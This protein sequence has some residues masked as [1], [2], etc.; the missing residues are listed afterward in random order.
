MQCLQKLITRHYMGVTKNI[1]D[2]SSRMKRISCNIYPFFL[3]NN[4]INS[5]QCNISEISNMV[6]PMVENVFFLTILQS[7]LNFFLRTLNLYFIIL[8]A[9]NFFND[10]NLYWQINLLTSLNLCRS[11]LFSY[12]THKPHLIYQKTYFSWIYFSSFNLAEKFSIDL[13]N[14][15]QDILVKSLRMVLHVSRRV[16]VYPHLCIYQSEDM[17]IELH[18]CKAYNRTLFLM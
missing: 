16:S 9:C 14:Y 18:E 8:F 2:N 3:I 4:K 17:F 7:Q 12:Q 15:L 6:K 5:F 13:D 11:F 10:Y 1:G